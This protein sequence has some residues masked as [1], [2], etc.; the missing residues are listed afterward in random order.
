[1]TLNFI[2]KLKSGLLAGSP[3]LGSVNYLLYLF[4][5]F[6]AKENER[7]VAYA[8]PLQK[9]TLVIRRYQVAPLVLRNT[10]RLYLLRVLLEFAGILKTRGVYTPLRGTQTV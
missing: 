4:I 10:L 6:G 7:R 1:M 8:T 9:G 5:F 2:K 3:A